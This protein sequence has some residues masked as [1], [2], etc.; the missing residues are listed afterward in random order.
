MRT[1]TSF[2]LFLAGLAAADDLG[3]APGWV[4]RLGGGTR[5]FALGNAAGAL[6]PTALDAWWNAARLPLRR[7]WDLS[8]S[9]EQRPLDRQG[10]ALGLATNLGSRLGVGVAMLYRRDAQVKVYDADETLSET[11]APTF[12]QAQVALGMRITRSQSVGVAFGVYSENL[13]L[14][15]IEDYRA[16]ARIDLSWYRRGPDTAWAVGAV[17]RNIGLTSDLLAREERNGVV[18]DDVSTVNEAIVPRTLELSG[19]YRLHPVPGQFLDLLATPLVHFTGEDFVSADKAELGIRAGLEYAPHPAWRLRCGYEQG[20]WGAGGSARIYPLGSNEDSAA[21]SSRSLWIDYA[22]MV[23]R[24]TGASL[25]S[26]ALRGN[27]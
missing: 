10:G 14:Q 7:G 24:E 8:M 1:V 26:I 5:E 2:A 25:L 23:E 12:L 3:G 4:G 20:S 16:P 6:E 18:S 13:D 21:V 11:S 22:A 19:R 27:L 17:L 15:G 9:L